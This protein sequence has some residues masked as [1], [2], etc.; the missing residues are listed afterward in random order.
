MAV[1]AAAVAAGF[2]VPGGRILGGRGT[3][4]GFRANSSEETQS[5]SI[6]GSETRA[7]SLPRT[8]GI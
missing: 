4:R 8:L 6:W 2:V 1:T 5:C 7:F 3:D